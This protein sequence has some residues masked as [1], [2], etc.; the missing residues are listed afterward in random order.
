MK[1][2]FGRAADERAVHRAGFEEGSL[3]DLAEMLVGGDGVEGLAEVLTETLS[4][5][6]LKRL[7]ELL[8]RSG[9]QNE[10]NR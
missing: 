10:Q 6:D 5:D 7:A 2:D 8:R 3:R 9:C 1:P 4:A